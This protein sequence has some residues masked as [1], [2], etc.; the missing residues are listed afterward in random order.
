MSAEADPVRR[1]TAGEWRDGKRICRERLARIGMSDDVVHPQQ[2][3]N[4]RHVMVHALRTY[5]MPLLD[6]LK[7]DAMTVDLGYVDGDA[8][9]AAHERMSNGAPIETKLFAVLSLELALRA[10]TRA[11]TVD[12]EGAL[13]T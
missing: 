10:L 6:R 3:E 13:C 9:R 11:P 2:R 4:M 8:L 12:R 5:G 1:A 7:S